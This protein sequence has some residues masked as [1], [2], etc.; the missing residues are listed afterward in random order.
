MQEFKP[1]CSRRGAISALTLA[2]AR[3]LGLP[4]SRGDQP[5]PSIWTPLQ[6]RGRDYLPLDQVGRFYR[7]GNLLRTGKSFIVGEGDRSLRGDA[8][9]RD[10]MISRI[11]FILS[12]P[13]TEVDG[14][15]CLSR[16]DLVK[17]IEPVLRPSKIEGASYVNTVILDAGHGGRDSGAVGRLG[18]E[19]VFTLDVALRAAELLKRSGYR[20][21]LTRST[22]EFVPLEERAKFANRFS[23]GLFVSIHFNAGGNGMGVETFAMSPYGVPSMSLEGAD[24]PNL[25]TYPGNARDPENAALATATHAA[26]LGKSGMVDRG[27]KRA[28]FYVLRENRLPGVL[29]EAGFMTNPDDMTKIATPW[30]RQQVA[31]G[32]LEAVTNYRKAVGRDAV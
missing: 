10:F 2:G 27:V 26:L 5:D 23:S 30:Y 3:I 32:I 31:T 17:L 21:Y 15:L 1:K 6:H 14:L 29:L 13:V 11:K 9:S 12:Y 20:V 18:A 19:K 25:S 8:E 16:V 24:L 22:D 7:F 28:R 4:E